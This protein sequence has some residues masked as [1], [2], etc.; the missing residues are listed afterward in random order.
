MKMVELLPFQDLIDGS[1]KYVANHKSGN[2][3][4]Y[5]NIPIFQ[6]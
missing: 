5:K 4:L 6:N 2:S 3:Q 1:M